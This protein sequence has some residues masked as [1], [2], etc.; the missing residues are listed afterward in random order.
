MYCTQTAFITKC[1]LTECTFLEDV[2]NALQE[3]RPDK[4]TYDSIVLKVVK[5]IKEK[6][7]EEEVFT[8]LHVE[9]VSSGA[10]IYSDENMYVYAVQLLFEEW[11][12][13]FPHL[14]IN[15]TYAYYSTYPEVDAFGGVAVRI[16]KQGTF[17]FE[18]DD[19]F[20]QPSNK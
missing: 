2:N 14:I 20:Q 13:L 6:L 3:K 10:Y 4:A 9:A 15:Y 12:K 16:N 17:T 18:T 19:F 8:G 11:V 5:N 1:T 7:N